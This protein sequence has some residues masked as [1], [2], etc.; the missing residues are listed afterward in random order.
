MKKTDVFI[1]SYL[2]GDQRGVFNTIHFTIKNPDQPPCW[3]G[4]S[5]CSTPRKGD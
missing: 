1:V 2:L 4:A 5:P 3:S